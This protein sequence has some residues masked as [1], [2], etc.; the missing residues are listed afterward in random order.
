MAEQMNAKHVNKHRLLNRTQRHNLIIGVILGL[1]LLIIMMPLYWAVSL[2]FDRA[3][4]TA[5]PNFTWLPSQFTLLNYTYAFEQIPLAR[6][7]AN[8][9]MIAVVNTAISVFFALMCGYA[10]AKGRFFLKRFWYFFMLAVM[11]I[12]FESRMIPLYLQYLDWGLVNTYWPLIFGNVAYVYGIFFA[13]QNISA[14]PDSLRES[15]FLDG[16]GEWKIFFSIVLP[17]SLP[18]M[19]ALSILQVVSQWNSYLW[20]M[21]IIR[22]TNKQLLSVGISLFNATE[23][24]VLYGPRFGAALISAVPLVILF[25][26][27]Q[28][29]IVQSIA[30]SGIKQ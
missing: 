22:N 17:L 14:L 8:T 13:T 24:A 12:P 1:I 19:S 7:F 23:N 20:P 3:A 15:A 9:V 6:Y 25:L 4:T 26:F 21:V 29:Y 2:S 16:A 10:F 27:L 11:M 18:V 28:K 30:M 5:L